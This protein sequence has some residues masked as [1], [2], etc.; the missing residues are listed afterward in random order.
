VGFPE[1]VKILSAFLSSSI[2]QNYSQN[3]FFFLIEHERTVQLCTSLSAGL[4]AINHF[5]SCF[6]EFNT[7]DQTGNGLSEIPTKTRGK[8]RDEKA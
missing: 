4:Y 1:S 8:G 6:Q 2:G 5:N 3:H 7:G